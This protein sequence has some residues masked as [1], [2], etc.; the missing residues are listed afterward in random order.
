MDRL[1]PPAS[2]INP[3]LSHSCVTCSDQAIPA[4]VLETFPD[5]TA[6]V[7]IEGAIQDV[8]I[9]LVDA[10]RGDTVLVHA[11][12]AIATLPKEQGVSEADG[13]SRR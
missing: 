1:Y 8:N 2:E 10:A 9:E 5:H 6:R 11:D 4:R 3:S 7:E 13:T 12:V